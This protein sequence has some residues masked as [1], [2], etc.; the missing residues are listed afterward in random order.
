M[1]FI[2]F[3]IVKLDL[4]MFIEM[5]VSW[6]AITLL[7]FGVWIFLRRK[8][9]FIRVANEVAGL[10]H[11]FGNINCLHHRRAHRQQH[12][13]GPLLFKQVG[14]LFWLPHFLLIGPPW[15]KKKRKTIRSII[16]W[17]QL[18]ANWWLW[19]F[20]FC[21]SYPL[22]WFIVQNEGQRSSWMGWTWTLWS[23]LFMGALCPW[24]TYLSVPSPSLA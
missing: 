5:P 23:I 4:I 8:L 11:P 1:G 10:T 13:K 21:K 24:T 9:S 16:S 14:S 17:N 19:C 22:N 6:W 15:K 12:F 7:G 20:G 3:V 18:A 2:R